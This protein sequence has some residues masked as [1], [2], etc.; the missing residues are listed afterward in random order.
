M[1]KT[2][3]VLAAITLISASALAQ[4]GFENLGDKVNS[5]YFEARPVISPDGKTLYFIVEGN[6]ANTQYKSDKA[7]QDV[8][9]SQL[10]D[11]GTWTPAKQAP[12]PINSMKDNAVFWVSPD[13]NKMLIRGAF[14]N[15]KYVG[16]GFSLCTK[17]GNDWG[18]PEKLTIKG[19][20][21]MAVDRFSGATMSSD[22]KTI[23]FYFSQEKNSSLNDLYVSRHDAA[24]NTWGEPVK[25]GGD[26]NLDDYDEISPFLAP[27]GSTLYYSSNRPGG[28]GSYDIWMTKRMDDSWKNWTT[29][30]NMGKSVNSAKFDAY[31]S[32]DARGEYGYISSEQTALGGT[33][34]LRTKLPEDLRPKTALVIYGKVINAQNKNP[35][36]DA[37]LSL[38]AMFDGQ[39]ENSVIDNENGT[40]RITVFYGKQYGL[41]A[42]ADKF[43]PLSDT[44]DLTAGGV[45]K[46]IHRD[47]YLSP[48][49][50]LDKGDGEE[51]VLDSLDELE[52]GQ[53]LAAKTILFDFAKSIIRAE[54]YKQ[55]D[56]VVRILKANPTMVIELSAHTDNIGA[57][58]ANQKL[59]DDRAKAAREYLISKGIDGSRI[60]SKGYGES[61]PVDN[62]ATESGRQ[63][64]R[65]VEFKIISK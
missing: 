35:M 1:K 36:A 25:L 21:K 15:G 56:K 20:D 61:K 43:Y 4:P 30:V 2:Q 52:P 38:D 57:I 49:M 28:L 48:D 39:T 37:K 6:P 5:A 14:D 16:R 50:G 24:S 33:D 64:N 40:Y 53:S 27:D 46:E 59:S 44:F 65:R 13:G 22:G 26:V 23:L 10:N 17:S 55:L 3:L 41:N 51:N 42:S 18:A 60:Q 58:A 34:I 19:Y 12:A 7:A 32:V 11:D 62:N 29:P 31:F 8:W 54:S 47:L 45:Y 63:N 9:S